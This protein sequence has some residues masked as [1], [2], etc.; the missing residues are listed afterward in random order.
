MEL[1]MDGRRRRGR[2]AAHDEAGGDQELALHLGIVGVFGL[3]A[4]RFEGGA[5]QV[6]ARK[7]DGGERGQRVLG[8]ATSSRPMTD[9][10]CGTR[11]PSM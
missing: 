1:R 10:S 6:S 7:A 4:Q 8:E 2:G 9:R 5:G 11:S 3:Q